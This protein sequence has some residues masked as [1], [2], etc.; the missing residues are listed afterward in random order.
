MQELVDLGFNATP[1]IV[2]DGTPVVGFDA[3][4]LK[5]LLGIK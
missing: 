2:V 5:G 1:V 3:A 4:K